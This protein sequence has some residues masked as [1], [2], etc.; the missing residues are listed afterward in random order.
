MSKLSKIFGG[1][2]DDADEQSDAQPQDAA[3]AAAEPQGDESH[4]AAAMPQEPSA[5]ATPSD[6]VPSTYSSIEEYEETLP[7]PD[8]LT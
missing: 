2:D 6:D 7:K 4:P 8:A 3:D 5:A 1:K